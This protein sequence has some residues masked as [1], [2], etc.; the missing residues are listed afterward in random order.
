VG[1]E[2]GGVR[3]LLIWGAPGHGW[4][5]FSGE[6]GS[7]EGPKNPPRG[8]RPPVNQTPRVGGRGGRGEGLGPR[9]GIFL[10]FSGAAGKRARPN[11]YPNPGG[12]PRGVFKG[13][14]FWGAGGGGQG[15]WVGG[16]QGGRGWG[17]FFPPT[18][19]FQKKQNRNRPRRLHFSASGSQKNRPGRFQ[20]PRFFSH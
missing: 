6:G 11:F 2:K 16:T 9:K 10:I 5:G 13:G 20:G 12:A 7:P 3:G 15:L 18:H 14:V 8:P 4:G 17:G 19:S 1:L